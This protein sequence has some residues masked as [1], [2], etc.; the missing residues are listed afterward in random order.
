MVGGFEHF[1]WVV[2]DEVHSIGAD[3]PDGIALQRLIKSLKCKFLALSATVGN[4][5]SCVHGWRQ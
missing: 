1:K 2:Y 5:K 4:V 3:T